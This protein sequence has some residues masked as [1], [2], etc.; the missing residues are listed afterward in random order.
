MSYCSNIH[1]SRDA[2]TKHDTPLQFE[3]DAKV[4]P[5]LLAVDGSPFS[6]YAV[7]WALHMFDAD[8]MIVHAYDYVPSGLNALGM[9]MAAGGNGGEEYINSLRSQAELQAYNVLQSVEQL[10]EES[11]RSACLLKALVV[12]GEARSVITNFVNE[13][14]IEVAVVGSR[15]TNGVSSR[16]LGTV[17]DYLLHNAACHVCVVHPPP[18]MPVATSQSMLEMMVDLPSD[19]AEA[20]MEEIANKELPTAARTIYI[21]LDGSE[22]A[23]KAFEWSRDHFLRRGDTVVLVM[24]FTPVKERRNSLF[25]WASLFGPPVF[26]FGQ[27]DGTD[28][29]S[30]VHTR[31]KEYAI[32]LS[33][34]V[35]RITGTSCKMCL[36]AG[37]PR[38]LICNITENAGQVDVLVLGS[39]GRGAVK[40]AV[41]GS[42]A[43]YVATHAR[44]SIM[45][46]K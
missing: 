11:G 8:F 27:E 19:E 10:F 16:M 9:S 14:R 17:S 37:D 22:Q 33:P 31:M 5:V 41:L 44:C 42:V 46:V 12:R 32:K 20:K 13:F 6:A 26:S 23:H 24:A 4:A 34:E 25:G 43:D 3:H 21:A 38:D 18:E 29:E 45:I 40:R 15:G 2:C 39:R 1:C 30:I 35:K 7:R 28:T 36:Q